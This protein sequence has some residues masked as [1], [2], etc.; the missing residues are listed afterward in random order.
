[1]RYR[2]PLRVLLLAVVTSAVAV[3]CDPDGDDDDM[4]PRSQVIG[5]VP[6][7]ALALHAGSPITDYLRYGDAL[8]FAV[9]SPGSVRAMRLVN[10]TTS[11]LRVRSAMGLPRTADSAYLSGRIIARWET[12]RAPSR[13]GTPVGVAY[14]WV[15]RTPAGVYSGTLFALSYLTG[16]TLR[17]PIFQKHFGTGPAPTPM[18]LLEE[19]EIDGGGGDTSQVCCRCD[20][21]G[22]RNCGS[23]FAFPEG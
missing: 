17:I 9:D 23:N 20:G 22:G 3:A 2:V 18:S 15:T 11:V 12:Y 4:Q 13:F 5:G 8:T 1:M 21:G 19:C 10:D 6:A 7:P 16:D 14:L